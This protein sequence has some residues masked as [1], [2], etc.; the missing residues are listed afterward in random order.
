VERRTALLLGLLGVLAFR[1]NF[2]VA[3]QPSS[4]APFDRMF[5][6]F[7]AQGS[8]YELA[9]AQFA[10]QRATRLDVRDYAER[11]EHDHS[12][13]NDALAKLAQSKGIPLT[14]DLRPADRARLQRLSMQHGAAFDKAFIAEAQRVNSE[15]M[16]SFR[17]EATRTTDPDIRDF[18]RRFLAVDEEH[19]RA[20]DELSRSTSRM[21]VIKPPET[22]SKMPVLPPPQDGSRM[23]VIKPSPQTE[24]NK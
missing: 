18:V 3:E 17:R 2:A 11:I 14:T 1:P 9:L 15:D 23:P 5:L 7:E 12:A 8:A 24:P 13:Y 4:P 10:K 21:P 6:S 19:E 16:R 22:G 20:A